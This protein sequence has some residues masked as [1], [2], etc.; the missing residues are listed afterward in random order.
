MAKAPK[1]DLGEELSPGSA[2]N[3]TPL[4]AGN[5]KRLRAANGLSLEKLSRRSGVS[6]AMLGQIELGQSAPTVNVVWKIACGLGVPFSAL[7]AGN[8]TT[9]TTVLRGSEARVLPSGGEAFTSR[10]LFPAQQGRSVEFY[11]LRIKARSEEEAAP[12]PAGTTENLV[13][14]E[15]ALELTVSGKTHALAAGDALY[16]LADVPH[17]YRNPG[18]TPAVIYL[19][20]TY[21]EPVGYWPP[22]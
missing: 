17:H 19:V 9:A 4:V 8:A 5:L 12:H 21:A 11:E 7:L 1:P 13:V 16:F 20:I 15:G 3:L 2:A 10:P 6:R 18:R 22:T 14:A